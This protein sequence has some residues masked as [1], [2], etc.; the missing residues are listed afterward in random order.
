MWVAGWQDV[1]QQGGLC[2]RDRR[3]KDVYGE[4]EEWSGP[5]DSVSY[6]WLFEYVRRRRGVREVDNAGMGRWTNSVFRT[7]LMSVRNTYLRYWWNQ[8]LLYTQ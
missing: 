3:R 7:G 8:G 4:V 1:W 5:P 2:R 6:V